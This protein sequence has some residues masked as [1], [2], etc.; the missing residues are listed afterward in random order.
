MFCKDLL[1]S[2]LL[3]AT[4]LHVPPARANLVARPHLLAQLDEGLSYPLMLVSAPPGFGKTTLVSE[5]VRR[6][7]AGREGPQATPP[8][9]QAVWLALT[10]EDNDIARPRWMV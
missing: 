10:E 8:V 4:K 7:T 9:I 1:M 5:W 3:L 6:R 2:E